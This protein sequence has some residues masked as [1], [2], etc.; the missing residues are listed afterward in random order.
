M[1][2]LRLT[3]LMCLVMAAFVPFSHMFAVSQETP[4]Y[5]H[6]VYMT[7]HAGWLHY[8]VNAWS[9]LLLHNLFRWYRV[10]VAYGCAV[11][12]SYIP[13]TDKPMLGAS[14]IVCFFILH[15]CRS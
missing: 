7:G 8:I 15:R 13:L 9:L 11:I 6:F 3:M 2:K 12:L 5:T 1:N 10:T 14:V 4:T